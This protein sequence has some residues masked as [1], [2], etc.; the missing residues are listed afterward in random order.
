MNVYAKA[1]PVTT[2]GWDYVGCTQDSDNRLL[3]LRSNGGAMTVKSCLDSCTAIGASFGGVEYGQECYCGTAVNGGSR[4]DE[5]A[6]NMQCT[7]GGNTQ[8]G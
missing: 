7:G 1:D 4:L 8:C 5:G 3:T 6:C 2:T